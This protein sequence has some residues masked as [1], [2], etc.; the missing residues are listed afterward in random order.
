MFNISLNQR[1]LSGDEIRIQKCRLTFTLKIP[2]FNNPNRRLL[3]KTLWERKKILLTTIL[4][5]FHF[6]IWRA[7]YLSSANAL[8]LDQSYVFSLV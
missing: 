3:L 1:I 4:T 5:Y 8:N 2:S 7:F 6:I